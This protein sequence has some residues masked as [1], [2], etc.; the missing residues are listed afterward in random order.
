MPCSPWPPKP[1][2]SRATRAAPWPRSPPGRPSEGWA[3]HANLGRDLVRGGA[4]AAR[5][6]AAV[7]WAPLPAWSFVAERY[8]G[9][10]G[11]LARLGARWVAGEHW[12]LDLSRAQRLAGPGASGWTLGLTWLLDRN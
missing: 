9:D 11:H 6:G 3:L 2:P 5:W 7:E 8:H 10:G 12:S 1:A 4:D